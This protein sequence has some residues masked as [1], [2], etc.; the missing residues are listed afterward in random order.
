MHVIYAHIYASD[1][2][3]YAGMSNIPAYAGTYM[4]IHYTAPR[5]LPALTSPAPGAGLGVY[6]LDGNT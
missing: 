3:I 5:A 6:V 4:Y 1:P 2:H